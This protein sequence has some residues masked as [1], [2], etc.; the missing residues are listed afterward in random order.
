MQAGKIVVTYR[1]YGFSKCIYIMWGDALCICEPQY[2][3]NKPHLCFILFIFWLSHTVFAV[4][5]ENG[6][7]KLF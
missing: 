5:Y 3:T 1:I 4:L 7:E 2:E 6:P